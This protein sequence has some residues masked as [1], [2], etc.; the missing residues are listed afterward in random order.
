MTLIL[1]SQLDERELDR[2]CHNVDGDAE[3]DVDDLAAINRSLAVHG[4]EV[5]D[6]MTPSID[7]GYAA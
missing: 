6:A 1:A 7:D 4:E 3:L 2:L 5:D